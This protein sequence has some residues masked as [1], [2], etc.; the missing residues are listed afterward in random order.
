MVPFTWAF[1]LERR[2]L[3]RAEPFGEMAPD[4]A[5]LAGMTVLCWVAGF[6]FLGRELNA[7]R[8]T[9]VLGSF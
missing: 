6:L 3:L 7:A 4:L 5:V 9:G 2:S 8:R 1:D